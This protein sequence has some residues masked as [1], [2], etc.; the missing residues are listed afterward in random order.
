MQVAAALLPRLQ[1]LR[2]RNP[3]ALPDCIDCLVSLT[4]LVLHDPDNVTADQ[5][6]DLPP[7]FTKLRR[8]QA[9]EVHNDVGEPPSQATLGGLGMLAALL[10]MRTVDMWCPFLDDLAWVQASGSPG[11]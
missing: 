6:V 4:K 3:Y 5:P 9:L 1:L 8:L 10:A 11:P 7:S 2:L